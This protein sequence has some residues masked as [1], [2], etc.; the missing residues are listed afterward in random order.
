[1]KERSVVLDASALLALMLAESGANIVEPLVE[2]ALISSVNLSETIARL[3]DLSL[4]DDEIEEMLTFCFKA[5]LTVHSFE[6]G[7]AKEAGCLRRLT[8]SAGLSLG[9]R[10]CLNLAKRCEMTA[11]TAD[12]SWAKLADKLGVPVMLIR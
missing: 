7:H 4:D 9:D 1:M 3:V 6:E 11:V 10:A 5:G 12:K 8:K 2:R